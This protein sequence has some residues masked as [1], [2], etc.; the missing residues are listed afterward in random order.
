LIQ[1]ASDRQHQD[2]V[3]DRGLPSSRGRHGERQCADVADGEHEPCPGRDQDAVH[4]QRAPL[5]LEP[6]EELAPALEELVDQPEDPHLL[7]RR[8]QRRQ[9]VMVP[10]DAVA[11]GLAV[12]QLHEPVLAVTR[13]PRGADPEQRQ[14]REHGVHADEHRQGAD[15]LDDRGD[16]PRDGVE[17]VGEVA[18]LVADELDLVQVLG[19]L[20][21]LQARD[22]GGQPHDVA[23]EIELGVL[24]QAH[25]DVERRVDHQ[26]VDCRQPHDERD[27]LRRLPGV[28]V[29]E[30]V[31]HHLEADGAQR[32]ARHLAHR[33]NDGE[34]RAHGVGAPGD[35][36]HERD[37]AQ[38][39]THRPAHLR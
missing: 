29:D 33:G 1:L 16:R 39:I 5:T 12:H 11:L 30:A 8:R 9:L 34:H 19:P 4:R 38:G 32:Q 25:P 20:V 10:E 13:R 27:A 6:P 31:G 37:G 3:A 15:A 7:G 14:Q 17:R 18:P 36:D 35:L 26:P 22:A 23:V 28:V 2:D 24:A 21:V